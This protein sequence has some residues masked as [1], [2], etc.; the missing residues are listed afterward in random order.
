M[1]NNMSKGICHIINSLK[2]AGAEKYVL[3]LVSS[4]SK[5]GKKTYIIS[6][7]PIDNEF[8]KKYDLHDIIIK[9][10]CTIKIFSVRTLSVIYKIYRF[11][12]TNPIELIH[13]NMRFSDIIGGTAAILAKCKFVSTQHDTRL[14]R[15]RHKTKDVIYK[16]IHRFVIRYSSGI[17]APTISVKH[18]LHETERIPLGK[19]EVIYHGIDLDKFHVKVR[20]LNTKITIGSL[21]R[22]R[23]EKGHKNIVASMPIV[24]AE[25]KNRRIELQFAGEGPCQ[26]DVRI[27]TKQLGVSKNIIFLGKIFDVPGFLERIDI[28]VHAATSGEAFCYAALEGLAAGKPVV[29]TDIDGIPE[30]IKDHYN[31]LLVPIESP[32]E[33]ARSLI[34]LINQPKLFERISKNAA[35]SCR[36][37]FSLERMI[38]QT[39][40]FYEKMLG[41]V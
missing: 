12:K 15:Y 39:Y 8:L 29:I 34:E 18:Y 17:I 14:W 41:N 16:Y 32:E 27:L 26:H 23:P 31:G 19:T 21:A 10:F 33:I 11:I 5:K 13:L 9:Q 28:L 24:L 36:P 22:F 35:S 40:R 7:G 38:N 30:F 1:N 2:A 25:I 3:D 4:M 20:R 6:L 37:F